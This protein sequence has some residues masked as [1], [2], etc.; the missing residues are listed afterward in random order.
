M[1]PVVHFEMPFDDRVRMA[2]FYKTAFGWKTRMFSE[3]MGNYVTAATTETGE[4]APKSLAGST[5]AFT[6]EN[7]IGPRN[8]RPSLSQL[9][10]SRDRS[11][12]CWLRGEMCWANPWKFRTSVNM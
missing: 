12:K 8:I 1:D 5:A 3:G 11:R 2:K 9:T 10:T 6:R 7:P 4:K